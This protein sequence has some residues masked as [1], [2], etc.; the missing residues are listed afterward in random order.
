MKGETESE[1]TAA[2]DKALRTKYHATKILRTER[3]K[4]CRLFQQFN[5][6]VNTIYHRSQFWQ[7]NNT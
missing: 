7:K 3:D 1:I 4:I 6:T 2:P 5:A